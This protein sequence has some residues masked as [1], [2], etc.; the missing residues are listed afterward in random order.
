MILTIHFLKV[1]VTR[2]RVARRL[3]VKTVEFQETSSRDGGLIENQA[4]AD[5][6]HLMVEVALERLE[7]GRDLHLRQRIR[8]AGGPAGDRVGVRAGACRARPRFVRR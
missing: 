7:S 8:A 6:K 5:L 3:S 4:Y 2:E 1:Q